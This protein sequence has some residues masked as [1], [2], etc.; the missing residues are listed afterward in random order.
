MSIESAEGFTLRI[1]D[2]AGEE[3]KLRAV[4]LAVFV[5][6]QNIPEEQEWDE[7]D[8]RSVHALAEECAGIPIGCARLL[9]DGHIGRVA[10]LSD[11]RGQGVGAALLARLIDVARERGDRRV[12]LN[13]QTQAMPFYARFGFAP[14]GSEF[15]EAGIPHRTM[16]RFI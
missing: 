5:V 16:E 2:W 8:A 7:F 12:L 15:V 9:P 11:Y 13:A 6:E 3:E 10:V 1:V 14:T 4:R